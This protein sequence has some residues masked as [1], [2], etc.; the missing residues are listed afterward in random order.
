MLNIPEQ[1][2]LLLELTRSTVENRPV[3]S[4]SLL[5]QTLPAAKKND[6]DFYVLSLLCSHPDGKDAF[7]GGMETEYT[8]LTRRAQ[9]V[10]REAQRLSEFFAARDLPVFF[11]KDFMRYPYTDHDVDFIA[12]KKSSVAAYRAGMQEFGYQYR[13][14]KSQIRE[15]DKYFYYPLHAE[16]EFADIR[17]HLH[18][19]VSWN[20]VV[21]LEAQ[22][23]LTCC[24]TEKAAAGGFFVPGPEDEILIMAAHAV[25]ENAS[26]RIGEILQWGLIVTQEDIDWDHLIETARSRH[27]QLG[28]AFF[29]QAACAALF[30]NREPPRLQRIRQWAGETLSHAGIHDPGVSKDVVLPYA[31]PYGTCMRLY[32]DK[33]GT[34]IKGRA[35]TMKALL[36]EGLSFLAFV[37]LTRLKKRGLR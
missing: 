2:H 19:A 17:F 15:P 18:E 33:M 6:I 26:I 14:G 37:W 4:V 35:L 12:V 28:L 23:V 34:D 32:L 7:P 31:I 29:L 9:Y 27:W 30:D 8:R 20:G 3:P 1:S 13:F 25:F 22:D 24:R 16:V 36:W 10:R 21:F 11:M 5:A